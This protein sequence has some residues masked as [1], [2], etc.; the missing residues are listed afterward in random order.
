MIQCR[1]R[2][3]MALK[4]RADRHK[5]TYRDIRAATGLNTTTLVHLANDTADG[6]KLDT[7]E[8]LCLYFGCSPSDLF[9]LVPDLDAHED[10]CSRK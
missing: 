3:L 9:V 8:R 1:L 6:V 7:I 5:V 2:E 4:A 10:A